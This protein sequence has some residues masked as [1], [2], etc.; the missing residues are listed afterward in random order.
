[1]FPIEFQ[2]ITDLML[3]KIFLKRLTAAWRMW[4]SPT[5]DTDHP[6]DSLQAV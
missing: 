6:S 1:M 4:W 2:R 5:D 3:I